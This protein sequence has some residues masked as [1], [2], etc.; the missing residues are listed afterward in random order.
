MAKLSSEKTQPADPRARW[1][2]RPEHR[3][4]VWRD[5]DEKRA[6]RAEQRQAR[7]GERQTRKGEAARRAGRAGGSGAGSRPQEARSDG[8][9]Y[10]TRDGP[11]LLELRPPGKGKS[12]TGCGNNRGDPAPDQRSWRSSCLSLYGG[13]V[14]GP[15]SRSL[16]RLW[17]IFG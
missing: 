12:R 13:D 5:Q 9:R 14:Y 1:R 3:H 4:L 15:W 17:K 10:G 2:T 7:S 8:G 6:A 11:F 16:P